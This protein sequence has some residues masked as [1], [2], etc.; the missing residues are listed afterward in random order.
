MTLLSTCFTL[1]PGVDGHETNDELVVARRRFIDI[2]LGP[3][4]SGGT[5]YTKPKGGRS[6]N[7]I[8]PLYLVEGTSPETKHKRG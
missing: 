4:A 2:N 7:R 1:Y 8:G 3:N 6:P 5:H